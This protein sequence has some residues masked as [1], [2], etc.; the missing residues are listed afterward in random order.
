M[1]DSDIMT[2]LFKY[3]VA[4]KNFTQQI[5]LV[6]DHMLNFRSRDFETEKLLLTCSFLLE[7]AIKDYDLSLKQ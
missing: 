5:E 4:N 2:H 1:T 6:I 3:R 7:Q